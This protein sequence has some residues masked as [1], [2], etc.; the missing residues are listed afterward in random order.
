MI[1][2]VLICMLFNTL[3]AQDVRTVSQV[4]VQERKSIIIPCWYNQAYVNNVKYL[5]F[6]D[7][8]TFSNY[9]EFSDGR[10]KHETI[11][12]SDN[13]TTNILTIEMRNIQQS[14]SGKYWCGI[15]G[16]KSHIGIEFNL[17]V[18]ADIAG[19][20]VQNQMLAGLEA[21]N[22]TIYC[23]Y[24]LPKKTGIQW[25]KLAGPCVLESGGLLDGALVNISNNN[26]VVSV[27]M[28]KLKKE[29]TGWYWCSVTDLQMPVHITVSTR[30]QTTITTSFTRTPMTTFSQPTSSGTIKST[31]SFTSAQTPL[32]SMGFSDCDHAV[33][34]LASVAKKY[35]PKE[36]PSSSQR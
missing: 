32:F 9:V 11:S 21:G 5:S 36:S 2:Y 27:N 16:P 33:Q 18:T 29:N 34:N 4:S 1:L 12:V 35:Q 23:Y 22:V 15:D 17:K 26:G 7:Y 19:L 14:Q 20:Y 3:G 24:H 25:C 31:R 13:K 10:R 8:W 30:E 28:S 6:G